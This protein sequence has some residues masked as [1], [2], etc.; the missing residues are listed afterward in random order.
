MPADPSL[1]HIVKLGAIHTMAFRVNVC[2]L[3]SPPHMASLSMYSNACCVNM[4]LSSTTRRH[5]ARTAEGASGEWLSESRGRPSCAIGAAPPSAATVRLT[6]T[7]F[8]GVC[9]AQAS[10]LEKAHRIANVTGVSRGVGW[11]QS[12]GASANA[13]RGGQRHPYM[14][15]FPIR[16]LVLTPPDPLHR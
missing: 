4:N 8:V 16:V 15:F 5:W 2:T 7:G 3:G 13:P 1:D 14:I 11:T 10:R 9:R 6:D 12:S